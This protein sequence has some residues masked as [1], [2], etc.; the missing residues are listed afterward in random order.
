M[1]A[2]RLI[3]AAALVLA[4]LMAARAPIR[5]DDLFLYL[6]LGRDGLPATDPYLFTISPHVWHPWHEWLSFEYYFGLY[7]LGGYEAIIFARALSVTLIAGLLLK[8]SLNR[9]Q[10]WL[11]SLLIVGLGLL[12]AAPR[13]FHDRSSNFTDLFCVLILCALLNERPERWRWFLPP[14]F[15]LWANLHSSFIFGWTILGL[16]VLLTSRERL[17]W[18]TCLAL[19]VLATLLTPSGFE[20]ALWPVRAIFG[21]DWGILAGIVEFE[22]TWS[23]ES[24]SLSYKLVFA[25]VTALVLGHALW[26][27]SWLP[28]ALGIL[29]A[30]LSWR[31][32][33]MVG[34]GGFGLAA[35][36]VTRW[37][38]RKIPRDQ[39]LAGVIV[40][41]GLLT[42]FMLPLG[43]WPLHETVP[44]DAMTFL[45]T[46]TPGRIFNEWQLGGFLAWELERPWQIAAHGFVSDP[47]LVERHIYRATVTREGWDEIVLQGG[48]RYFMLRRQTFEEM[49]GAAWVRELEGPMWR[50]IFADGAAVIFERVTTHR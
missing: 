22:P 20:G 40:G 17:K 29:I 38:S 12:I 19:C 10:S 18:I 2:R 36:A 3:F 30:A 15:V 13:A 8:I 9:G 45:R 24:V 21:G 4:F 14:L 28:L 48:V 5:L 33:R 42:P 39:I 32:V 49:R 44:T 50:P 34:F 31:Y 35:L 43:R 23:T 27:R 1:M 26:R 25:F 16:F 37:P 46:Q 11:V 6:A 41:C 47:V 7:S